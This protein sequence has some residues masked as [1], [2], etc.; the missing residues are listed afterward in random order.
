MLIAGRLIMDA[1]TNPQPG[2][3]R[4][5][6]DRIIDVEEGD[7][8]SRPDVGGPDHVVTPG[9]VDCHLHFPQF[10]AIGVDGLPLLDWLKATVYPAEH[11]WRDPAWAQIQSQ[12]AV[13]RLL[14]EGT[15]GCAAYLTSHPHAIAAARHAL[16]ETPLRA[17]VGRVMM[18]REA[19]PDL[20]ST[21]ADPEPWIEADRPDSR[22]QTAVTPRFAI[23]CSDAMLARAGE[24]APGRFVQTHLGEQQA[25]IDRTLEFYPDDAS[26]TAVYDRFGLLHERALLGHCVHL[27]SDEW[28]LLRRRRGVAV[29]CP[30]ANIFLQSGLFDLDAARE[31]GVRVALGSDIAAGSDASMPRVARAMIETAKARRLTVAPKAA[32]PTPGE[33]WNMVTRDNAAALGYD[34]GGVLRPGAAADLLILR[35]PFDIDEHLIGRLLYNWSTDFIVHRVLAGRVVSDS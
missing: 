6:G 15:L 31:H 27:A 20:C 13:R 7:P 25:E 34:D 33:A 32:I 30:Q 11:A 9:F 23:A 2:W 21:A 14:R 1:T 22:T 24:L 5:E 19:P 10:D 35:P 12:Q 28:E 26:Y 4:I 17:I 29:H 8:P 16:G 18:D 3:L